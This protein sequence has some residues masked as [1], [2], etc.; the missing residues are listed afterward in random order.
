MVETGGVQYANKPSELKIKQFEEI[1]EAVMGN[2]MNPNNPNIP[3]VY[4]TQTDRNVAILKAYR[5]PDEVINE[6]D[7][8]EMAELTRE[9]IQY[10]GEEYGAVEQVEVK[11]IIYRATVV[12][13]DF[14]L[15]PDA[16]KILEKA[17]RQKKHVVSTVAALVFLKDGLTDKEHFVEAHVEVKRKL[18]SKELDASNAMW[19]VTKATQKLMIY[20]QHMQQMSHEQDQAA[21]EAYD[22]EKA[23]ED[24]EYG[25]A[26]ANDGWS[27]DAE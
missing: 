7:I 26:A 22:P 23:K 9:F 19:F 4:E 17:V 16:M 25:E 10:T 20:L 11:G 24:A 12:N 14:K 18:F 1:G 13:D 21:L 3:F 2:V 5:V 15:K 8:V 6:L 27:E